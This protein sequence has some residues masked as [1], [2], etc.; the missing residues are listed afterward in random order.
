MSLAGMLL[1]IGGTDEAIRQ[2][3]IV[4]QREK[5]NATAL[6]M[7]AQAYRMKQLYPQSIDSARAAIK[8]APRSRSRICG[9]L[10]AFV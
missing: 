10:R 6:Y 7:Q 5:T 2:L 1:D 8:F 4:T 9:S 3:N